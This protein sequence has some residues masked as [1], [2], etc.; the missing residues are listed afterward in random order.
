MIIM[1]SGVCLS[2]IFLMIIV[3]R[4]ST[5]TGGGAAAGAGAGAGAEENFVN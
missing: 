5:W 4:L 1:I 3:Q 2:N